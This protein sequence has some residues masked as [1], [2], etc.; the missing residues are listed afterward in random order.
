LA[1][2]EH[3]IE[4]SDILHVSLIRPEGIAR[5]GIESTRNLNEL[6]E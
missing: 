2:N 5:D 6:H 1:T 3:G 4:D